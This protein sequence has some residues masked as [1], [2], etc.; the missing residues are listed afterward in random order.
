MALLVQRPDGTAILL[1][2]YQYTVVCM[3]IINRPDA[4]STG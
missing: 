2:I 4:T 3:Q 1:C